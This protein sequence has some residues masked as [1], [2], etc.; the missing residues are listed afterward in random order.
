MPQRLAVFHV[1]IKEKV[2]KSLKGNSP[3]RSTKKG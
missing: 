2:S 1:A 3:T